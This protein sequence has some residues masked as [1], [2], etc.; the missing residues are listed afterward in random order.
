M[1]G[2]ASATGLYPSPLTIDGDN[3]STGALAGTITLNAVPEPGTWTTMML[4]GFGAAG[5]TIRRQRRR[6]MPQTA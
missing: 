1:P 5:F 6:T 2:H 4:L 3:R